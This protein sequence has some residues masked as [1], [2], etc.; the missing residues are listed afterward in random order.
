MSGTNDLFDLILDKQNKGTAA[1]I[2]SKD[3]LDF[4]MKNDADIKRTPR[5]STED[6]SLYIE[7]LYLEKNY[8]YEPTFNDIKFAERV[9]QLFNKFMDNFIE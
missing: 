2:I 6:K 8:Y 3:E 9:D 4:F 1:G 5:K 7:D